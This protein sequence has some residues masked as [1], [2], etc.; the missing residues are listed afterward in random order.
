VTDHAEL[1]TRLLRRPA[2]TAAGAA[3]VS[4]GVALLLFPYVSGEAYAWAL[5]ICLAVAASAMAI[6]DVRTHTL[7]NRYVSAVA[8]AG[9]AQA[10]VVST[11]SHNG[12]RL[13]ES[14]I[15]ASAVFAVY[16]LLGMAGW[17]G[18]GDAKFAGA[19][20]VTVAIYAGLAAMY[21]V[22]LAIIFAAMWTLACRVIGRSSF[23]RAHGPA[24][25]LAGVS[26]AIIALLTGQPAT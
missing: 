6:V 13:L 9:L 24:I 16:L 15:A 4:G 14:L 19:L 11:A 3:A 22:P 25:A 5:I 8:A 2:V 1:N 26:I 20:T 23:P 7:P 18:F 17:F 21:L 12:T 10:A